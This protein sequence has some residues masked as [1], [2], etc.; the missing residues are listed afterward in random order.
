MTKTKEGYA[1][2]REMDAYSHV[3][4]GTRYPAVLLTGGM[5]EHPCRYG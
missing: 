3:I 4:D 5:N 2:L 1:A